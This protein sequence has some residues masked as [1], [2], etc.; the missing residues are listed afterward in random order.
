MKYEESF[1]SFIDNE[2]EEASEEDSQSD[3]AF[4][5]ATS[6]SKKKLRLE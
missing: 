2:A 1:K 3:V 4:A 6:I 5:G